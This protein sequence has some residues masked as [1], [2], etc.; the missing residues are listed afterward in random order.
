MT[1]RQ[2]RAGKCELCDFITDKLWLYNGRFLCWQCYIGEVENPAHRLEQ[3]HHQLRIDVLAPFV[4]GGRR[5]G[6]EREYGN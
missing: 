2:Q 6:G 1:D 4:G 5:Q 3:P